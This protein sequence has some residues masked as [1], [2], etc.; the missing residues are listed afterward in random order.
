ML[1]ELQ[2][3]ERGRHRDAHREG[4]REVPRDVERQ[5]GV[6]ED[7]EEPEQERACNEE[8]R[9]PREH[10]GAEL[11]AAPHAQTSRSSRAGSSS[12]SFIA[13]SESTA[14]RPSMMRWSYESAR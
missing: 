4:D 10:G 8:E 5:H 13:T 3:P 11:P 9:A 12:A 2:Q 14:S 7:R 6:E 1:H